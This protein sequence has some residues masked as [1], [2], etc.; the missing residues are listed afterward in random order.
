MNCKFQYRKIDS[1]LPF[2]EHALKQLEGVARFLL[3]DGRWSV[4]LSKSKNQPQVQV[5]VASPWGYF[6]A[7]AKHDDFYT[8]IDLAA[9]K[10]ITQIKKRKNQLQ[11]H[12]NPQKTKKSHLDRLNSALEYFPDMNY[13]PTGND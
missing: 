8:A 13:S 12:K 4:E 10:L 9:D 1:S 11:Y 3:K 5:K 6:A 7:N 2:E